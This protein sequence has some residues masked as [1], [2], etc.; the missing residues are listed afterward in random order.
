L[1]NKPFPINDRRVRF[2]IP[3]LLV[4]NFTF[5]QEPFLLAITTTTK[6][7]FVEHAEMRANIHGLALLFHH[8]TFIL[9]TTNTHIP[10]LTIIRINRKFV[11]RYTI[12]ADT[13]HNFAVRALNTPMS[14]R[15]T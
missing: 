10:L 9:I 6:I 1:A 13:A 14:L 11:N 15:A 5:P 12:E 2:P 3:R 8:G 7:S 4:P